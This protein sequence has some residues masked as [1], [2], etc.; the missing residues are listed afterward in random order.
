RTQI[1]ESLRKVGIRGYGLV[2]KL[3]CALC[4]ALLGGGRALLVQVQ[5]AMRYS[6][7]GWVICINFWPQLNGHLHDAPV[8]SLINAHRL[9]GVLVVLAAFHDDGK[10]AGRQTVESKDTILVSYGSLAT[11]RVIA[12]EAQ[13][14]ALTAV[15]FAGR[16]INSALNRVAAFTAGKPAG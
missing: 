10:V 4:V 11:G 12:L 3:N 13:P 15:P 5:G 14:D 7:E 8:T 2:E 9:A 1:T 16:E 6:G